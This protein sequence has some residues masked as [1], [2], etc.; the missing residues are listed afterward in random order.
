MGSLRD[1]FA[2]NGR[3]LEGL[4]ILVVIISVAA[5]MVFTCIVRERR[6]RCE[7]IGIEFGIE[8]RYNGAC[9]IR[10]TRGEWKR[11]P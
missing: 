7:R 10:T 1:W 9:E 8:V 5:L 4:A 3:A 6:E 11:L 2:V